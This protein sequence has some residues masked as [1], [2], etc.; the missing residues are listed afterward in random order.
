M[1]LLCPMLHL[2]CITRLPIVGMILLLTPKL[3]NPIVM[4]TFFNQLTLDG[5]QWLM[6]VVLQ[7]LVRKMSITNSWTCK[8][9]CLIKN[10]ELS[11]Q[12]ERS[13]QH[14]PDDNPDTHPNQDPDDLT[15]Q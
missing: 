11:G 4:T 8:L 1:L 14:D 12:G 2:Q 13:A 15:P 3:Q 6:L 10:W 7:P 9:V 5:R